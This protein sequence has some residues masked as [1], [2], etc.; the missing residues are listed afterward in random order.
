MS[1]AVPEVRLLCQAGFANRLR[2]LVSGICLAQDL[3]AQLIIF[4][5]GSDSACACEFDRLIS[6][7]SWP[8]GIY[9]D[10]CLRPSF[11]QGAYNPL[12]TAV[13]CL[14]S[15]DLSGILSTWDR[16]SHLDIKS[17]GR[18]HTSDQERWLTNLRALKPITH[19]QTFVD[20]AFQP[21]DLSDCI[22]VH[23]RRGDNI[24]SI[25]ASPLALFINRLERETARHFIVATDDV[26][27]VDSLNRI[28]PGRCIFP[29]KRR[30]RN[31]PD[32]MMNGLVDFF[33][34]AKCSVILGSAHSSYSEMAAAYGGGRLELI[35]LTD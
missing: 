5:P 2:A 15:S 27:V 31:T 8:K 26:N 1:V 21:V 12:P 18:F 23:I 13:S 4:W 22:G 19:I 6:A 35:M 29:S 3:S 7:N 16:V 32:G 24:K 20:E 30:N 11:S 33:S 34:L 14:S 10:S 25:Q 28:F 17:Y 9:V